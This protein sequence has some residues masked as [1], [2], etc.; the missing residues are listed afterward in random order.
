MVNKFS[1]R[2]DSRSLRTV[3]VQLANNFSH[4]FCSNS[5]QDI[6]CSYDAL[7]FK[8]L[9]LGCPLTTSCARTS[10]AA[11]ILSTVCTKV[12]IAICS[13]LFPAPTSKLSLDCKS[14]RSPSLYDFCGKIKLHST[15]I[16]QF[17][18][19]TCIRGRDCQAENVT[20]RQGC[21]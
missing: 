5:M 20:R 2:F 4:S 9:D 10:A 18:L 14:R 6:A 3:S 21:T 13:C 1:R 12:C 11:S 16:T 8:L 17:Y 19:S 7:N 15:R